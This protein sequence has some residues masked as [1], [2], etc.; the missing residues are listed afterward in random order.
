M[1]LSTNEYE[2]QYATNNSDDDNNNNNSEDCNERKT[3]G[4]RLNH[5]GNVSP[6]TA[7]EICTETAWQCIIEEGIE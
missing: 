6:P 5:T 3:Y 7:F 2:T 4:G 1:L